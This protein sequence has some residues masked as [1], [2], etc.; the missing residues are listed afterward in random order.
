MQFNICPHLSFSFLFFIILGGPHYNFERE[1]TK[2]KTKT[3]FILFVMAGHNDGLV[4][5]EHRRAENM[6]IITHKLRLRPFIFN[7]S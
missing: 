2:Q 1:K 5:V 3:V 4:T 6:V 7:F